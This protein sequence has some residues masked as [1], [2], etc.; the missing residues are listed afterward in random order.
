ME[1][2][3]VR[4]FSLQKAIERLFYARMAQRG[5]PRV[6]VHE[7]VENGIGCVMGEKTER[8]GE[9]GGASRGER[10]ADDARGVTA[11]SV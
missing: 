9:N 8:I 6:R 1:I 11:P 3:R 5:F 10:L 2:L 7:R 4:R